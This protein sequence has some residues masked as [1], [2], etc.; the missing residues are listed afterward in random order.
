MAAFWIACFFV[1]VAEMGDKTQIMTL[2]FAMRYPARTVMAGV[3]IATLLI[4]LISVVV[5]E[6]LG[7][8]LPLFW[9]DLIAGLVFIGFGLWTMRSE[10]EAEAEASVAEQPSLLQRL[11]PIATVGTTFF[12]AEI[13]DRTMLATIVIAGKQQ[14]FFGVWFGSTCGM[15]A[16]NGL[17]I[18][19]GR[20]VGHRLPAKWLKYATAVIFVLSGV[21]ALVAAYQK[22]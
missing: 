16:A 22:H 14:N 15:V 19:F 12:L 17:A 1:F 9:I 4:H 10:P 2:T 20:L 8:A 3:L 13:G 5:G 18:V 21:Y 6:L 7:V 11:G